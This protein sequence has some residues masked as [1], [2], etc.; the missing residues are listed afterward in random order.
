MRRLPY[1]NFRDKLYV[2]PV[3]G[4]NSKHLEQLEIGD[5]ETVGAY[6]F[7]ALIAA[8]KKD[9]A[10]LMQTVHASARAREPAGHGAAW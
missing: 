7:F 9:L 10:R 8:L 5:S 3:P 2:R 6:G 1:A 4:T